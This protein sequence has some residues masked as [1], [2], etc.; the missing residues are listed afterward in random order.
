MATLYISDL[1]IDLG[2]LAKGDYTLAFNLF[3][4][5]IDDF[6]LVAKLGANSGLM[7]LP[8]PYDEPIDFG[9]HH[10]DADELLLD[11]H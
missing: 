10:A 1:M 5:L 4:L 9:Y 11:G 7:L 8:I 6:A 2:P 3:H